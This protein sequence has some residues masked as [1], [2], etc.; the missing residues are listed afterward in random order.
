MTLFFSQ[1]TVVD[2]PGG[3]QVTAPMAFPAESIHHANLIC[4]KIGLE[5]ARANKITGPTHLSWTKPAQVSVNA[6]P[7]GEPLLMSLCAGRKCDSD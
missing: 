7:K 3:R 1:I 5:L 2:N 6:D 4:H